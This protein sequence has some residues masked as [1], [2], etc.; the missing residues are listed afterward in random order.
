M[1][2]GDVDIEIVE[3]FSKNLVA[4][5]S[6][7]Q[8]AKLLKKTYP[9]VNK[10]VS[11]LVDESILKKSVLGS[12]HLCSL[13]L[14]NDKCIVLLSLVEIEKRDKFL[15]RN[16]KLRKALELLK[17]EISKRTFHCVLLSKDKI[18]FV[19]EDPRFSIVIQGFKSSVV[20]KEEFLDL[21][22]NSDVLQDHVIV[23]G[24]D[25]YF[26]FVKEVEDRLRLKHSILYQK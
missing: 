14:A 18:I 20:G 8:I 11:Y 10:R 3:V 23:Y 17:K 4:F 26:E 15:K 21:L 25:R 22:L 19:L 7:N 5:Y 12:S 9:Y 1:I 24:F 13:N 2:F 16:S 6:I